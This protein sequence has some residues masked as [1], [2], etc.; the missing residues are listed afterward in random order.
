MAVL[1]IL[2]T[3]AAVL[4]YAGVLHPEVADDLVLVTC[5]SL[6]ITVE[7]T[8]GRTG[9][10]VLG[11]AVT[12]GLAALSAYYI[13]MHVVWGAYS[14]HTLRVAYACTK[15]LYALH[16]A[17]FTCCV[18]VEVRGVIRAAMRKNSEL[19]LLRAHE[20]LALESYAQ[21]ASYTE[22]IAHIRHDIR[23]HLMV[24]RTLLDDEGQPARAGAYLSDLLRQDA[25]VGQVVHTGNYLIDTV[26]GGKLAEARRHGIP[27]VFAE[28]S[29]PGPMAIPESDLA[30]VLMNIL[31]N[32]IEASQRVEDP[33]RRHIE[34]RMHAKGRYGFFSCENAIDAPPV[35]QGGRLRSSKADDAHGYGMAVIHKTVAASGGLV[36]IQ[37][38]PGS[39][40][41]QV[42][43]PLRG[44]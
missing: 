42:L 30:S 7:W 8:A 13:A 22:E 26:V 43:I 28:V 2:Y 14:W 21:M 11:G 38:E 39:F 34:L 4:E 36:D 35:R 20:E 32:A 27:V 37:I 23:N 17:L 33:Q 16:A 5:L 10:A 31:D 1:L 41:I 12:L 18:F 44:K 19:R 40:L 24:L 29:D 6:L 3:G 25:A 9:L 15:W